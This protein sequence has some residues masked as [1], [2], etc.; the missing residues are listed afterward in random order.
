MSS[1]TQHQFN[2]DVETMERLE[3]RTF[4]MVRGYEFKLYK[5]G[6]KELGLSVCLFGLVFWQR[7]QFNNL[8]EGGLEK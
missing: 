2:Q 6:L 5:G 4:N 1:F 3:G 8:I 7:R